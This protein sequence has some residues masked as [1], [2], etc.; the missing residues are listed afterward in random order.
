MNLLQ[1]FFHE[2]AAFYMDVASLIYYY[3]I[4]A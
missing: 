3:F 2:T 1:C 4:Q